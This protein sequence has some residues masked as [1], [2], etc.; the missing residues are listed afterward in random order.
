MHTAF[1]DEMTYFQRAGNL[2]NTILTLRVGQQ[3]MAQEQAF[4]RKLYDVH[5]DFEVRLIFSN[6]IKMQ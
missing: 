2:L 4:F 3:L 6:T 1:T 5:I